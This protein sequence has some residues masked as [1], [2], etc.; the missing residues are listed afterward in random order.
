LLNALTGKSPARASSKPGLT[1]VG[2]FK[3]PFNPSQSIFSHLATIAKLSIFQAMDSHMQ[4]WRKW[5]L[6]ISW[7]VFRKLFTDGRWWNTSKLA[8]I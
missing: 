6:G 3:R 5:M 7:S 4:R 2:V 8:L 1:Q